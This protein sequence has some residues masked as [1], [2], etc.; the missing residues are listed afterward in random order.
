V[1]LD[2]RKEA[3]RA[4][5]TCSEISRAVGWRG[6]SWTICHERRSIGMIQ[7][8]RHRHS[9]ALLLDGK[10]FLAGWSPERGT[11]FLPAV[12]KGTIGD[13]VAARIGIAGQTPRVNVFGTIALVRLFGRPS[14]PPG[15]EVALDPSSL[16]AARFLA[17]AAQGEKLSF[18]DR[19]PRWMVAHRLNTLWNGMQREITT[20]NISEGGCALYW[21][22]EAPTVHEALAVR[23][24]DGLFGASARAVV[25][26]K[27]ACSSGQ[28]RL[29]LSLVG[30]ARGL[31][32]WR[33]LVASVASS[34]A[35]A[36]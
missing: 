22:S 31:R 36:G 21:S 15:V 27:E 24:S 1:A 5:S 12:S 9:L 19:S 33:S 34:G 3:S 8:A 26:W 13:D 29:G 14:I 4:H 35:R 10:T 7:R 6:G 20:V 28:Q 2:P 16:P 25:C 32:A 18:R 11:L 23:V 17:L 30:D